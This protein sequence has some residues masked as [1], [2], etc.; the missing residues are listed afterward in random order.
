MVYMDK[1]FNIFKSLS[2]E[3]IQGGPITK[4]DEL[5]APTIRVLNISGFYTISCNS[6]HVHNWVD[7]NPIKADLMI[8][9][10]F[11]IPYNQ[12]KEMGFTIPDGYKLE[13]FED[14]IE[15]KNNY[16]DFPTFY[17]IYDSSLFNHQENIFIQIMRENI[18]LYEWATNMYMLKRL[19]KGKYI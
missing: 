14:V 2:D 4:I 1:Y 17:I 15:N 12:A 5:M 7:E 19:N 13:S 16:D 6:G 18:K 9:I 3:Q 10:A 11:K 8:Y